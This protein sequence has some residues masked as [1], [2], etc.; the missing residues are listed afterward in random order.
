ML[1]HFHGNFALSLP[2][3]MTY[4]LYTKVISRSRP[5]GKTRSKCSFTFMVTPLS[6]SFL[7]RYGTQPDF[8]I[9]LLMAPRYGTQSDFC[10]YLIRKCFIRPYRKYPGSKIAIIGNAPTGLSDRI[11]CDLRRGFPIITIFPR[12]ITRS[13]LPVLRPSKFEGHRPTIRHGCRMALM[14]ALN[15]SVECVKEE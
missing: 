2:N 7:P 1:I 4:E 11:G 9:Y 15:W 13:R 10:I 5:E 6:L 12:K 14:V 3:L 8:C